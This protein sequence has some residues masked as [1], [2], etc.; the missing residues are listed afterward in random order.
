MRSSA[1]HIL[2]LCAVVT[3]GALPLHAQADHGTIVVITGQY[4]GLP[5]PT[6]IQGSSNQDVADLLFLRLARVGPSLTTVGDRDF[7]PQLAERWTRPDSLTIV[8]QLDPRARWQDG[9]AVT[10]EDVV[11]SFGRARDAAV[12]PVLATLLRHI[13]SVTALD[14]RRVAVRFDHWYPSQ[15]Y[16]ATYQV[17]ILPAHLLRG[18]A[19]G[20]VAASDFA[21][22]PVGSGPYTWVRGVPGQFVEL[23]AT[24]G[25]FLGEPRLDRVI[26]RVAADA[27]AR[28]NLLLSGEGDALENILP[29]ANQARVRADTS[30][31]LVAVPSTLIGYLLYNE[32]DPADSARPNRVLSDVTVRRA[33]TLALDRR[34]IA[35]SVFGPEA[36]VPV[37]PGSL[38]L[39]ARIPEPAAPRDIPRAQA[40]LTTAGWRDTDGDGILDKGG[41]PLAL[42]L[43]YPNVSAARRQVALQAQAD[44]KSVG[45][46]VNLEP[47]DFATY[48][49][50]RK[51][52]RF[53]LDVNA[54]YQDPDPSGLAQSWSCAGIGGANIGHFCDPRVDSL[55][56]AAT[57]STDGLPI[58]RQALRT[59]DDD[60]AAAF[61]FAPPVMIA[62]HRRY[63]NVV[64]HPESLWSGLG[65]WSV[66][67]GRQLP[68]DRAENR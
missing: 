47:L 52:G 64:F 65:D 32:R 21:R 29:L 5:I 30:L 66:T 68:R 38:A 42:D 46:Q 19:P 27:D 25:F 60:A 39:W 61:L 13:T 17:Q 36:Q 49:D 56:A 43:I 23:R 37:G 67:P 48:I 8:F 34:E 14:D 16:D 58:W 24:K 1:R 4:P 35:R 41:H 2:S 40:L 59:I 45:V 33:L 44:W 26:F 63:A 7:V 6:L 9:V 57:R 18:L 20:A 50:R 55:L 53:D 54:V 3:L 12:N 10:A 28:M 51:R 62:V 15:F 11:F 31:R 22:H